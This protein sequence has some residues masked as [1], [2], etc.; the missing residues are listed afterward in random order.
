[1]TVIKGRYAEARLYLV[2]VLAVLRPGVRV[3]T[4]GEPQPFDGSLAA[5][6]GDD[7]KIIVEEGRRMIDQQETDLEHIRSRA[8]TLLTMGLAEIAVLSAL[9][10]RVFKHSPFVVILWC[11]SVVA[12]VLAVGGAASVLTSQA[13]MGRVDPRHVAL[14]FTPLV[15]RI[16][17]EYLQSL[18]EGE[19]TVRTR[20][21]VLRG[22]VL[23]E[24]L[25][26][27]LL[28]VAWPFTL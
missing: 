10:T 28:A 12:V 24:T 11:L 9:A 27:L 21:T 2:Y 13:R 17:A 25:A 8:G 4:F 3:P 26:A 6:T 20:L 5:L 15:R 18:G 23:L 1:M 14:E 19:E 7:L 22:A 16:A